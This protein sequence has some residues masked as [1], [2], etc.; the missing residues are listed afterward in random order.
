MTTRRRTDQSGERPVLHKP[1]VR[2]RRERRILLVLLTGAD[3]L[4]IWPIARTARVRTWRVTVT[5]ALLE[6]VS[7]VTS[8]WG[9]PRRA[10][11]PRPRYYRLTPA[12]RRWA[13]EELGLTPPAAESVGRPQ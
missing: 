2:G 5:L 4:S 12:G 11:G 1:A 8:E 7:A 13:Y 10:G 9:V 6:K 3:E